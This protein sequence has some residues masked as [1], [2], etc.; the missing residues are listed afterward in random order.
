MTLQNPSTGQRTWAAIESD[1]KI[2]QPASDQNMTL[3]FGRWEDQP[4]QH[5]PVSRMFAGPWRGILVADE[6]GLGKTISAMISIREEIRAVEEGRADAEDNPLKGAPHT[7]Q[8]LC[9]DDWAHPY[10][11]DEAAYP[12]PW[13]RDSKFWPPV[14]RVDNAYGDRNLV[15]TCPSVEDLAE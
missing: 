13:L 14:G 1:L 10:S 12:A 2:R 9:S 11:R 3:H 7:A 8:H 5:L 15:C 6:V 4:H